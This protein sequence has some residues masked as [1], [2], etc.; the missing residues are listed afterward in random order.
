MHGDKFPFI[1]PYVIVRG[2]ER[3]GSRPLLKKMTTELQ[4]PSQVQSYN[5]TQAVTRY[6]DA[7]HKSAVSKQSGSPRTINDAVSEDSVLL[8]LQQPTAADNDNDS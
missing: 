1:L 7:I 8:S 6:E 5:R 3:W 4:P 2:L